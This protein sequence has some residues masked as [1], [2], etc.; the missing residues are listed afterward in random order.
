MVRYARSSGRRQRPVGAAS[1]YATGKRGVSLVELLVVIAIVAV[2][3]GLLLPAVQSARESAR[4]SQC[5][6]NL[7]QIG[8]A[9][10]HYESG[11]ERLPPGIAAP[12][13]GSQGPLQAS[14][15]TSTEAA[16]KNKFLTM[17]T[18]E[19]TY[20]LHMLLPSFDE[21]SYFKAIRAPLFRLD[22]H[23]MS[24]VDQFDVT[25]Y[26]KISGQQ[27]AAF[28]C[29]SDGGVSGTWD[30]TNENPLLDGLRLAKSNYL[31]MFS[32][33]TTFDSMEP[34]D[35]VYVGRWTSTSFG[36]LSQT[37]LYALRPRTDPD[38][39]RGNY[40]QRA[41]FGFG[42]GTA[43]TSVK[44]GTGKTIAVVE[45]LRGDSDTDARGAFWMNQPGMQMIQARL[46]PNSDENDLLSMDTANLVFGNAPS[47]NLPCTSAAT[48]GSVSRVYPSG[49]FSS[50]VTGLQAGLAGYAG[51]RS[52]HA[53]GVYALF[54]DG[55]VQFIADTIESNPVAPY[56]TWQRLA[57]IDD[58]KAIQG[59]Y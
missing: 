35:P 47:S 24:T 39:T 29:P 12:V 4:K 26:Q 46:A 45:Y 38:G 20:F 50:S 15:A 54:C 41:V 40:D 32:G 16:T 59:E 17:M 33:L 37:L 8:T 7:K 56:G 36:D 13:W 22:G 23:W 21:Q 30:V 10:G 49:N 43:L 34:N 5:Q 27:I 19:W 1:P 51:T 31:G 2:L 14:I 6:G 9:L 53:G 25:D 11:A 55:H 57:W 44:D 52:R 42:T 48:V 18:Y 58:G 28:L 3:V